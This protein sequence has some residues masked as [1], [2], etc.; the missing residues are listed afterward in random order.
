MAD[1]WDAFKRWR[2]RADS[3]ESML[4]LIRRE[5]AEAVSTVVRGMLGLVENTKLDAQGHNR[6]VRRFRKLLL[7][8]ADA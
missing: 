6:E 4:G 2:G 1:G 5:N 3:T 8:E 7:P